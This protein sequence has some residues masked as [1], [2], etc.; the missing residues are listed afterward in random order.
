LFSDIHRG[1]N[2]WADDF[3][4][5]QNI[6][7]RALECYYDQGFTYIEVGDVDELWENKHFADIRLAH[8]HVF[9]MMRRFYEGNR[10]HIIYGNH[11]A[12]RQDPKV[13]EAL[14]ILSRADGT[15]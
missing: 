10:L 9:W 14:P 1:N 3:A 15:V 12:E 2:S 8:S 11:D 4:H 7:F 5:N 13:V 6:L